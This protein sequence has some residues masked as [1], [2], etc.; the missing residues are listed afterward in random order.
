MV[1]SMYKGIIFGFRDDISKANENLKEAQNY[2]DMKKTYTL[3]DELWEVK[4]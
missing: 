2:E 3:L 1:A 4:E